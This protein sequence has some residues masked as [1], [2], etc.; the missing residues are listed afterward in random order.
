MLYFI[1]LIL[2]P[3]LLVIDIKN[4]SVDHDESVVLLVQSPSENTGSPPQSSK[5][6]SAEVFNGKMEPV[7]RHQGGVIG[8]SMNIWASHWQVMVSSRYQCDPR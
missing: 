8:S 1:V 2:S 4:P 6:A 3:S 7:T 5:L